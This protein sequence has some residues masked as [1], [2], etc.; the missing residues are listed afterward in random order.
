[1]C[2]TYDCKW[3]KSKMLRLP[4][5]MPH[6]SPFASCEAPCQ[7]KIYHVEKMI[8][9]F[10][11]FTQASCSMSEV[12]C[13]W[14]GAAVPRCCSQLWWSIVC[15]QFKFTLGFPLTTYPFCL[16]ESCKIVDGTFIKL[17]TISQ[18][19]NNNYNKYLRRA[20]NRGAVYFSSI[21][22]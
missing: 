5:Q 11:G 14:L 12:Y 8:N 19:Y 18:F 10:T 9:S 20:I 21:H 16:L 4:V 13:D 7:L 6:S 22:Y 1:M 17:E 15:H 2:L 3:E